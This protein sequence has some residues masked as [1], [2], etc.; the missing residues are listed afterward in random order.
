[1]SDTAVIVMAY[2]S[3]RDLSEVEAY[4]THI[5][6]GRPPAPDALEELKARY[7]AIGGG[8]PLREITRRQAAALAARLGMPVYAAMKHSHPFIAEVARQAEADGVRRLI[9]LPL[10]PHYAERSLGAYRAELEAGWS[11]DLVFVPGFHDRPE[12]T[13]AV[14]ELLAEALADFAPEVVYFTAHSLPARPEMS[15]GY[16]DRLLESARLVAEG[17]PRLP[18]WRIAFQ[19]ASET[20]EPW[21]GPDLLEALAAHPERK[22]VVCPIGFVADHLEILYDLDVEAQ[23]FARE[24]GM[25]L[26]RTASFNDRE[27]FIAALAAVVE[28][29]LHRV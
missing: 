8:S 29:A 20:G 22:V 9:G 25:E 19:S 14:Q 1:M 3:P 5:R 2:G 27:A 24:R 7:T 15:A 18:L 16:Q 13:A 10:A 28:G 17:M 12:F 6:H 21:L 26:R 23:A 11:G 4:Y